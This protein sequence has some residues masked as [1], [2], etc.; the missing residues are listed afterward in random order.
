MIALKTHIINKSKFFNRIVKLYIPNVQFAI[1]ADSNGKL[2]DK[3][4]E[5][6]ETNVNDN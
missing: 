6:K 3:I 1:S 4:S 2:I 5:T